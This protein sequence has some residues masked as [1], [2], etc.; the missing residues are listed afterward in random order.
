MNQTLPLVSDWAN[1]GLLLSTVEYSDKNVTS[2]ANDT[3]TTI[4]GEGERHVAWGVMTLAFTW[5]P[6]L[7][8][9]VMLVMISLDVKDIKTWVL[10][11]IRFVLWPL[12]VPIAM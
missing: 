7:L 9:L 8:G 5:G 3:N 10:L 4:S 12:L 11:P 1:G 6:A 2:T